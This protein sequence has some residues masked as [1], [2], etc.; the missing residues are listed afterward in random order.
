MYTK[1]KKT[2]L[3]KFKTPSLYRSNS[4]MKMNMGLFIWRVADM[5]PV[6]LNPK[7]LQELS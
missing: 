6:E 3:T 1:I 4:L 7:L 2:A 5:E